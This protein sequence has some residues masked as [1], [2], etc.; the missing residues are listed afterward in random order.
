MYAVV[1]LEGVPPTSHWTLSPALSQCGVTNDD[2]PPATRKLLGLLLLQLPVFDL[3]DLI[4]CDDRKHFA[5]ADFFSC[6]QRD[7]DLFLWRV[8]GSAQ[9]HDPAPD[10]STPHCHA[11]LVATSGACVL[12]LFGWGCS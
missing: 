2:L 11:P 9:I 4:Q 6:G 1:L 10:P 8:A 12:M 3:T 7:K 5:T